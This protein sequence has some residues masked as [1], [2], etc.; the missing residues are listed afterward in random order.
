MKPIYYN[1]VLPWNSPLKPLFNNAIIKLREYGTF[2]Y[3]VMEWEGKDIV[4]SGG[5]ELYSLSFGQV[6]LA[7]LIFLSYF[8]I[9]LLV[10]GFEL[11]VNKLRPNVKHG[12]QNGKGKPFGLLDDVDFDKKIIKYQYV[13]VESYFGQPNQALTKELLKALKIVYHCEMI[14]DFTGTHEKAPWIFHNVIMNF[15]FKQEV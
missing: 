10:L 11:V 1:M 7:M 8:G 5:A 3:L 15:Q 2:D 14:R 4:S 6:I 13:Q 12:N 9:A